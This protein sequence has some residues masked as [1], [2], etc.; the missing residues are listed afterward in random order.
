MG[1]RYDPPTSTVIIINRGPVVACGRYVLHVDW[2]FSIGTFNYMIYCCSANGLY[3][4]PISEHID[5]S[6]RKKYEYECKGI[7]RQSHISGAKL[8]TLHVVFLSL[9]HI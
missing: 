3:I 1:K 8:P 6:K 9:I 2:Y 7:D 4:A 5:L